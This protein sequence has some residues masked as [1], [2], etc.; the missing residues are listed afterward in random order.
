MDNEYLQYANALCAADERQQTAQAL[1]SDRALTDLPENF[2]SLLDN[3]ITPTR[4]IPN[5][6][7]P[8]KQQALAAGNPHY[9]F[10]IRTGIEKSYQVECSQAHGQGLGTLT[11]SQL[12]REAFPGAIYRYLGTPYRVWN[13]RHAQGKVF[14]Q[15][16]KWFGITRPTSQTM[17]FPQFGDELY[18]LI[19]PRQVDLP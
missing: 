4:S 12:L 9:A 5:E 13:L 8:L 11:Y 10:P 18:F 19:S 7:Y 1:Y 2:R 3:E 6:L 14:A 16:T 15:R 17:V